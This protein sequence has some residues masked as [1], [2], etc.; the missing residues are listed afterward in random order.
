MT[1]VKDKF[2]EGEGIVDE[3]FFQILKENWEGGKSFTTGKL[4]RMVSSGE[5]HLAEWFHR[6]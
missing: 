5:A 1:V 2:S 6:H 3:I 4:K